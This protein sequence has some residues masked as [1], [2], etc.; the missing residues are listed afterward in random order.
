MKKVEE[1]FNLEDFMK[2]FVNQANQIIEKSNKDTRE[3][4]I[5]SYTVVAEGMRDDFRVVNDQLSEMRDGIKD[6]NKRFDNLENRFDGLENRFDGLE[7]R[8]NGLDDEVDFI[9][10]YLL[11]NLEPRLVS[12]ERI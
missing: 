9:K 2:D 5:T 4:A 12:V 11:N 6:L 10:G 3:I 8:F 7:G 1:E